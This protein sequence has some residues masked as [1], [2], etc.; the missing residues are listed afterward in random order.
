MALHGQRVEPDIPLLIHGLNPG[1]CPE[2]RKPENIWYGEDHHVHGWC[3]STTTSCTF[4]PLLT[5]IHQFI[6]LLPHVE[7]SLV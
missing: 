7:S 3:G 1:L 2:T 5:G 4:T 6:M